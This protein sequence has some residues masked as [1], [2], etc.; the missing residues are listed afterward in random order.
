[1]A[2]TGKSF[3]ATEAVAAL[4]RNLLEEQFPD[5]RFSLVLLPFHERKGSV[6]FYEIHI[7]SDPCPE[8]I[9][10]FIED[11]LARLFLTKSQDRPKAI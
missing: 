11:Y 2:S 10:K 6:Y 9:T 1:M 3:K 4:V 8:E 7:E 5:Q